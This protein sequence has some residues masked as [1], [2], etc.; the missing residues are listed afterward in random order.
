MI[1]M[2]DLGNSFWTRLRL[3]NIDPKSQ[4][5][6]AFKPDQKLDPKELEGVFESSQVEPRK[7]EYSRDLTSQIHEG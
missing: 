4:S 3:A 2:Q 1:V 5:C 6:D 7:F